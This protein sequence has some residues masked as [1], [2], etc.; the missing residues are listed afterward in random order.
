MDTVEKTIS[1]F[2]FNAFPQVYQDEGPIFIAFVKKYYE[3]LETQG[4]STYHARRL[5]EYKDIDETTDEYVVYFKETYLKN[6]QLETVQNT[7]QLIKHSLDLYRSKGSERAIDLLFKIAFGENIRVYYPSTDLFKLSDG[8]WKRPTY[9]EVT[10]S[11]HNAKFV[12]KQIYGAKSKAT[13]FVETVIRRQSGTR[14]SDVLYISNVKGQFEAGEPLRT[15]GLLHRPFLFGSLNEI[16]VDTLGVGSG[17]EIGDILDVYSGTGVGGKAKVLE[18]RDS[19]GQVLLELL[20]GGYG[21]TS[22]STVLISD[23][24]LTF[25]NTS[26]NVQVYESIYQPLANLNYLNATGLFNSNDMITSYHANGSVKGSARIISTEESN[27]TVGKLFVEVLTGNISANAIYTSGNIVSANLDII[28]GFQDKRANGVIIGSTI[29]AGQLKVGVANVTNAF[30]PNAYTYTSNSLV[31]EKLGTVSHGAG[32]HFSVSN[33]MLYSETV[34]YNHDQLVLYQNVQLN[35]ANYGFPTMASAN[36]NTPLQQALEYSNVTFG[37]IQTLANVSPG[38][39]YNEAPMIRIIE[40]KSVIY[41]K[42]DLTLTLYGFNSQFR[43]GEIITQD[44]TNARGFVLSTNSTALTVQ[45]MRIENEFR[46]LYGI[47]GET[48]GATANVGFISELSN[49]AIVGNNASLTNKLNTGFGAVSKVKVIKSGYGFEQDQTVYMSNRNQELPGFA[50]VYT[51]GIGEG[52]YYEKGGQLSDTK[53]LYDGYYW[54][55]FSYDVVSSL[56]LDKYQK[57]LKDVVHMAGYR[58][59]GT[60]EHT[61]QIQVASPKIVSSITVQ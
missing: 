14:L 37:K 4:N 51:S 61:R 22:N 33:N 8:Y 25:A 12:N 50:N 44:F 38:S 1:N 41:D 3:W 40:P 46:L 31:N 9:L 39:N 55:D 35:A 27:T 45:D 6:I 56:A 16:E 30:Y 49:T 13:A 19:S 42:H 29:T 58:L 18:T 47:T 26:A 54:Q 24:V 5:F 28:T 7:R 2:V 15:D 34:W 20:D 53:K 10:L 57:L 48:S 17:F 11:E 23:F 36:V 21:F 32:F 60:L 59:F 43:V 52:Y